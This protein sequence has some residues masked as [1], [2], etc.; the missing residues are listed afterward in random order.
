M[1]STQTPEEKIEFKD[2]MTNL[3]K[4][5]KSLRKN[6]GL[7][8]QKFAEMLSIS[9]S[10]VAKMESG[11][12]NMTCFTLW[13]AAKALNRIPKITFIKKV[14]ITELTYSTPITLQDF[15]T[16]ADANPLLK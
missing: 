12:Q 13:K 6:E 9:Q 10:S 8:Q 15:V 1:T 14:N 4:E 5:L 2:W 16:T 7:N 3:A 11:E